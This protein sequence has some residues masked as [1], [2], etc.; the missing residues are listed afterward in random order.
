[1]YIPTIYLYHNVDMLHVR[2]FMYM[3]IVCLCVC[4]CCCYNSVSVRQV[5]CDLCCVYACLI[6]H[7]ITTYLVEVYYMY[8]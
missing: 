5:A 1:M 3:Y 2:V 8:M 6:C 7:H 4:V